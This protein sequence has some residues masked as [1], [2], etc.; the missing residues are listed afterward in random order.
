MV[1]RT[2]LISTTLN[3][4]NPNFKVM[5]VFDAEYLRNSWR[6]SHSCYRGRTGNHTQAFQWY[7]F[8]WP[9]ATL[10]PGF[11]VM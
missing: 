9:W 8:Q 11:K 5:P 3:D 6:Y 7:H 1:Y 4:P 10:N 2:V